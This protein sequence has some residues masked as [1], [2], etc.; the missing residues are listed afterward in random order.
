MIDYELFA[1]LRGICCRANEQKYKA[2]CWKVDLNLKVL[3]WLKNTI[4]KSKLL[5]TSDMKS[6]LL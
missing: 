3:E 2:L 6:R 5:D 1:E 4:L